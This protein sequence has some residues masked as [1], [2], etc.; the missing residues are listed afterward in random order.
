[1]FVRFDDV[2]L[3]IIFGPTS[4]QDFFISLQDIMDYMRK[5]VPLLLLVILSATFVSCAVNQLMKSGDID[6][7]YDMAIRYYKNKKYSKAYTLFDNILANL[8]GTTREDTLLFYMGKC[9]YKMKNYSLAAETFDTYRKRFSRTE[10]LEEAEYLHAMCY[11]K[12][13]RPAEKDQADTHQAIISFNEYMN[14]YP[15]SPNNESA[16]QIIDELQLKLYDKQYINASLYFRLKQY[17]AAITSLKRVI[18]EHPEIPQKEEMMY[19]ICKSWYLYA[20]NSVFARQLDRYMKMTDSYFNYLT[21]YPESTKYRDELDKMYA[22]SKQFTDKYGYKAQMAESNANSISSRKKHID[23][24]KE[25]LFEVETPQ[26][27]KE[28]KETIRTEKE[29]IREQRRA[30]KVD[31]KAY[32]LDRRAQNAEMAKL[33]K[34]KNKVTETNIEVEE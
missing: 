14:R 3:K 27:R 32:K 17:N 10:F 33:K 2:G 5:A 21:F 31:E 16:Q 7:Q 20:E 22:V 23:E 25:K 30:I 1:M 26:E 24:C 11:Y 29:A 15:E 18:K 8:A 28:L 19:L 4:F 12:D 6:T 13:S 34:S 9:A